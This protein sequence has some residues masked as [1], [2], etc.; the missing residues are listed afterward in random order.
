M[1]TACL[2]VGQVRSLDIGWHKE[3]EDNWAQLASKVCRK[4]EDWRRVT[5]SE[6]AGG[7]KDIPL[8]TSVP[9]S[10]PKPK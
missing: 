9:S 8:T 3:R 2:V 1:E 10:C 4:Q 5:L 6:L 7:L